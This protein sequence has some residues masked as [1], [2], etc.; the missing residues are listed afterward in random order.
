MTVA[1]WLRSRA[2]RPPEVLSAR[3]DAVLGESLELPAETIPEV[4]LE[5]GERLV[6]ELL[7]THS[8]SR[9]SALDLLTADAL[10][11]YAFEAASE[12][13]SGVEERASAA[14]ARIAALCD[15]RPA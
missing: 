2:S 7:N 13:P 10:V 6:A 11:T 14:M 15:T 9:N 3:L 1:E 5:K 12:S 4:F 8:T